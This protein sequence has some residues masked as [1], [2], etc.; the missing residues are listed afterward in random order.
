MLGRGAAESI[1][2]AP[3]SFYIK[4]LKDVRRRTMERLKEKED[5]WLYEP[6]TWPNGVVRNPCCLWF[7]VMEDEINHRGQIR[8]LVRKNK[9]IN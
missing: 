1:H 6:R 2:S 7:H 9:S 5:E 3:V 8:A 4:Q